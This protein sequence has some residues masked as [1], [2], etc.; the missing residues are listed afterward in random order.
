[1]SDV[2]TAPEEI[3]EDRSAP[4]DKMPASQWARKNL[5]NNWYN[6]LL[7]IT[8][9]VI[10]IVVLYYVLQ[11]I[12]VTGQ[13]T[14][15]RRN[16][17]LFMMGRFPR[18]E[19]WR[20]IVQAYLICAS[21]GLAWGASTA[22]GRD[23][24]EEAGVEFSTPSYL[25][26]AKRYWSIILLLIV[27]LSF[28]QTIRPWIFVLSAMG[29]LLL[30]RAVAIP[31]PR[32]LRAFTWYLA[33]FV[34]VA[35]WQIVTGTGALAQ[36][37][38]GGLIALM[39]WNL[40]GK[41]ELSNPRL[42][43]PLQAAGA[44][45]AFIAVNLIY[46]TFDFSGVGWDDWSGLQL[47]VVISAA[48]IILA[49]PFGLLL[50]LGRRSS[51]PAIRWLSVVYIELI[52]GVPLIS[53]LLAAQFFLGF[54]LNTDTP[55]SSVTR[56]LIAMTM[57]SA[58]YIAEIVRGGLQAVPKGQIEAGQSVGLSTGRI[59]ASIVLPQALRAVIPPMVGQFIS[60]FKD[61]SLLVIIG[62]TEFLGVREIVH[63]QE[64]FRSI[65]IA[66]TLVFVAFGFWAI[67][68]AMSRESQRLE[69]T[70]GVGER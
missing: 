43:L 29:L 46:R 14:V 40:L 58:A 69:R 55:L 26:L 70:L 25:V 35:S 30:C 39:A 44:I 32:S 54:L 11:F 56:A 52:R 24:A 4:P 41:I 1:M 59:M 22:A 42:K 37:W 15:V 10:G 66:E 31:L 53:L 8:F 13:W 45:G 63:A 18:E 60:L 3:P 7:T 12:F 48:A 38:M 34:G 33:A 51:L 62:F 68:F 9:A 16:L 36:W 27:L 20:L 64:D 6:A 2:M 61:S 28:A 47:T 5:F 67:A 23:K 21:L 49:F 57:F 50:A 65:A 19:Q 17:T